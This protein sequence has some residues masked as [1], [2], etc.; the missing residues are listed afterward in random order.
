[1]GRYQRWN[2][3]DALLR[4]AALARDVWRHVLHPVQHW[5]AWALVILMATLLGLA[6]GMLAAV[7]GAWAERR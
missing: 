3:W 6:Y 2:S 5:Q 7:G 4:P 1:L